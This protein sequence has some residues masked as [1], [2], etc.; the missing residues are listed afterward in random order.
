MVPRFIVPEVCIYFQGAL[1]RGN[2][3]KKLSSEEFK[4]F[5]SPNYP[6]SAIAELPKYKLS[7]IE[8]SHQWNVYNDRKIRQQFDF[9]PYLID[10]IPGDSL[11]TEL[12]TDSMIV[13]LTEAVMLRCNVAR[14]MRDYYPTLVVSDTLP[15]SI[16][17]LAWMV[18]NVSDTLMNQK[19]RQIFLSIFAILL[20]G[21]MPAILSD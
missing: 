15:G 18:T 11:N 9:R 20:L 17:S 3:A 2:R 21:A 16:D 13:G 4:A 7:L 12:L 8:N 6:D 5:S 19:I 1:F 14:L 10:T